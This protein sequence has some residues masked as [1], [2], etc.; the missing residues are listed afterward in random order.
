[1]SD[2]GISLDRLYQEACA[3]IR[4]T[5]DI[6]FKLLGLVPLLSGAAML[7]LFLKESI[8]PAR[9]PM[10]YGL[11]MFAALVTL[12]L[13]RWELRNIQTCKWLR[14][15]ASM[16]EA[17]ASIQGSSLPVQPTAP[18][19]IGKAEAE[20][21]V[22]STTIFSW[23]AVPLVLFPQEMPPSICLVYPGLS[24]AIAMATLYSALSSTGSARG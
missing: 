16:L 1:M 4:A 13:F 17:T 10:I 24:L 20:K 19:S 6:S 21:W 14:A 12:G 7:V 23:L 15:R 18:L 3:G 5:D 2:S 22:Y 8:P 11:A 9:A